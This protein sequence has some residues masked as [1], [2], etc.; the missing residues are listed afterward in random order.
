MSNNDMDE[1]ECGEEK[2]SEVP[3]ADHFWTAKVNANVER[4]QNEKKS[5]T[6]NEV[7]E[8]TIT[9]K[10][11]MTPEPTIVNAA[12]KT[13]GTNSYSDGLHE[14]IAGATLNMTQNLPENRTPPLPTKAGEK[15]T[16]LE[17]SASK[18]DLR[19]VK[20]G[21]RNDGP[22]LENDSR[23]LFSGRK[24]DLD[25][26]PESPMRLKANYMDRSIPSVS[27][28][29]KETM[30]VERKLALQ[31]WEER[32]VAAMG[33]EAFDEM[34]RMTLLRGSRLH[35]HVERMLMRE[36]AEEETD[37]VVQNHL[38]SL[39]HVAGGFDKPFA[40]E[41][42]V[43]HPTLNYKGYLDCVVVYNNRNLYLVDWK[44]SGKR[45]SSAKDTFDNP[46]Q[47]AAYA[48]AFNH[49]PSYASFP[50]LK[51][52]AIVVVYNDG[53]PASV[54]KLG[55]KELALAWDKWLRRLEEFQ[56]MMEFERA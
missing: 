37:E 33:R 39:S 47:I 6:C 48:G 3:A 30:P 38:Q 51:R 44:T 46:L 31:R 40:I 9:K 8:E 20:A 21:K 27:K 19:R 12:K 11:T 25:L 56:K 15:I 4:L 17:I 45:K 50:R 35:S 24:A 54:I 29:L 2:P 53:T 55:E 49:D 26:V 28:V 18:G 13:M 52:G 23:P 34:N 36:S 10:H 7:S 14:A 16:K 42:F 43:A 1:Y 41:S 22:Q 5:D 32:M